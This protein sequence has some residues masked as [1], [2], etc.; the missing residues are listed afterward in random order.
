MYTHVRSKGNECARGGS[1]KKEHA[2]VVCGRRYVVEGCLWEALSEGD[3]PGLS[4]WCAG[5]VCLVCRGCLWPPYRG[6]LT[7]ATNLATTYFYS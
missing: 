7:N 2:S 5:V 4:V 1:E 3:V 6:S